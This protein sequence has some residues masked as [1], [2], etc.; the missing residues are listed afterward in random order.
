MGR[1]LDTL[2]QG[3]RTP[4]LTAPAPGPAPHCVTDWTLPEEEV[5]FIEVGGPG[6][7][8]E[9]SPKLAVQPP[10]APVQRPHALIEKGVARVPAVELTEAAPMTVAF[11]PWTGPAPTPAGIAPEVIA[12]H[13]PEHPVSREYANLF[14]KI[15]R[16]R[17]QVLLLSGSKPHV[18]ASTVLL[19]LA[20]TAA[21]GQKRVAVLDAQ[22][23]RPGLAQ[24]LGMANDGGLHEVCA[25]SLALEQAL[26]PTA[27][28]SLALLSAGQGRLPGN[29]ALNWLFAWLRERYDVVLIDGPSVAESESLG[30]LAPSCD[31]VYLVLPEGEANREPGQAVQRLGGRLCGLIHTR[32]AA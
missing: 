27:V 30:V 21:L 23:V 29:E 17:G 13:Q 19:N 7:K 9:V 22:T 32:F 5:P 2:R 18:G 25:G 4:T 31:G 14:D 8:V 10:H 24:R 12:F 20:V 6:K 1:T 16:G 3:Q 11:E 28:P 26:R 15:A